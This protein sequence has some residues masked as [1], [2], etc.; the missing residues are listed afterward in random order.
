MLVSMKQLEERYKRLRNKIEDAKDYTIRHL[1]SN[2]QIDIEDFYKNLDMANIEA[3]ENNFHVAAE[4]IEQCKGEVKNEKSRHLLAHEIKKKMEEEHRKM[5]E[6]EAFKH[7][8]RVARLLRAMPY[9]VE[10]Q[11]AMTDSQSED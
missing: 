9:R 5:Q 8:R 10:R 7:G 4:I 3:C 1:M 2:I 11:A 6:K